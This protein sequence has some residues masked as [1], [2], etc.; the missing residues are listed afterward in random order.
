M[1]PPTKEK[2]MTENQ[3]CRFYVYFKF[4]ERISNQQFKGKHAQYTVHQI[5]MV[6]EHTIKK[7]H[8]SQIAE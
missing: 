1:F 2:S 5:Q 7:K 4:P 8:L 6:D 3:K